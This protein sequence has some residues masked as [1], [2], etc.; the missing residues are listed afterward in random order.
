[1]ENFS[2]SRWESPPSGD[3]KRNIPAEDGVVCCFA[4]CNCAVH[5]R[6][7]DKILGKCTGSAKDSR[8]TKV[9]M[10]LQSVIII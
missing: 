7:H 2:V 3:G 1:V 9:N 8:E 10:E 5:K 4:V 6:C